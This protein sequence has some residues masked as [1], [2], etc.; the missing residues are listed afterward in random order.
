MDKK[1]KKD[2]KLVILLVVTLFIGLIYMI[3]GGVVELIPA[4]LILSCFSIPAIYFAYSL[5][6]WGNRWENHWNEKNPGDG[7]PTEWKIWVM[8]GSGWV[9]FILAM[10]MALIRI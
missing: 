4:Y 5:A 6:R 1:Q 7:E 9:F 8:K 10:I 2:L 3:F